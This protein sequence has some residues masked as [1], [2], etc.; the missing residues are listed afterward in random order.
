MFIGAILC[1]I[2][3]LLG[4]MSYSSKIWNPFIGLKA[5]IQIELSDD[6]VEKISENPLRYI[7]RKYDDFVISMESKGYSVEQLGSGFVLQK[8][9]E[10]ILLLS[11]GFMGIYEIFSES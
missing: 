8:G 3:M 9:S 11:E 5:I 4:V 2:I 10:I 7:S 1:L 6:K